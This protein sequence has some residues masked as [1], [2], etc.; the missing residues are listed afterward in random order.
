M[1]EAAAIALLRFLIADEGGV[2]P[3]GRPDPGWCCGEHA[4]VA[5]FAF[6]LSGRRMLY[7]RGDLYILRE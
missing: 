6:A 5:Y 1:D 3:S 4:V 2:L 7:C